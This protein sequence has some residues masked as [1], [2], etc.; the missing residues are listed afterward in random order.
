LITGDGACG[1]LDLG[2]RAGVPFQDD[3]VRLLVQVGRQIA[4][5]LENSMAYKELT[6]IKERLSTERLY[7][8]GEVLASQ[9][10]GNM[11]GQ[12]LAFQAVLRSLQIVA[13]TDATVLILGETGTGKELVA[14]AIHDASG[15]AERSFVKVNCATIPSGLLESELFGHE[16]GAF[17]SASA[18]KMGRFELA[19]HGTLFLD[20]VGE[21][22]LELQSKLLR[23]IQEQ[24]FERLGGTRTIKVDTRFVAATN[25]DLKKMVDEGKFRADLYYRLHVFPLTMPPLRER[26]DDIP[27]LVRH[28]VQR[29]AQRMKRPI[30]S[31]PASVME[32]LTRYDWPGNVR[33]L[34]NVLERS[35][36]LSQ[37]PAL[38]VSLPELSD[39]P[40]PSPRAPLVAQDYSEE[41]ERILRALK[42]ADGI[43]SGPTGAAARLGMKRTTLQSRMRKL[44]ISRHYN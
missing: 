23:G 5:A 10:F 40:A 11:V 8:E 26:K 1:V 38:E 21:I 14:R 13:P 44:N 37:G 12:S 20:E 19:D 43:V 29:Y 27:L 24:E 17:T 18:Q 36:I 4:I 31:I 33:E 42:E 16:K 6:E 34:Q 7:L 39:H 41:R 3:E 2:R 25:R 28:F 9:D 15:R 32:A 30:E 22:P 35:V